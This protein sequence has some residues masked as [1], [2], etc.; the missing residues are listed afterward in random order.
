MPLLVALVPLAPRPTPI[1]LAAV[2][3]A[4]ANV[5]HRSLPGWEGPMASSILAGKAESFLTM[6]HSLSC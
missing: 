2:G 1:L 3:E 4:L 6:R 5:I